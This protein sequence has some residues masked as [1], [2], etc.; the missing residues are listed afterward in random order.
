MI[1]TTPLVR[2]SIAQQQTCRSL[3]RQTCR[4]LTAATAGGKKASLTE[5]SFTQ[6]PPPSFPLGT[7]KTSFTSDLPP[8]RSERP[9]FSVSKAASTLPPNHPARIRELQT[10]AL[11]DEVTGS[12]SDRALGRELVAAWRKDGILQIQFPPGLQVLSDAIK[13]S[14]AFF[15]LPHDK[16][17]KCVDSQ[18]FAGYI[19]SGEEITDGIADYSEIF[20]VTKDLAPSDSRV[21]SKW[22]CHGPCPWPSNSY[23]DAITS[24]MNY[25]G[26]I[27]QKLLHLTALGLNLS[28]PYALVNLTRDGWHHMRVLRFPAT[29]ATNGKGKE[30][31]GIG[32]H[33]DYGLLV[34]AAQDEVGGLFVRPPI[35]GEKYENWKNSAAGAYEDDSKWVYVAPVENVFTVFPGD[36]LQFMTNSYLP[37]TPHKV[38][39][40]TR[41]RFAFAYFHE[42]NFNAVCKRLPDFSERSELSEQ[43]GKS[44]EDQEVHYGTHFTNMF[45]RNYLERITAKRM[46]EEKRMDLLEGMKEEHGFSFDG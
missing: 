27:G 1:M 42:P 2:C 19:A 9:A 25:K 16:K 21:K 31:R 29:N 36:M 23:K 33:T 28:N 39:L 20:T 10:F 14:K 5:H 8:W 35:E 11:P 18:S 40:N 45:M 6:T 24:L 44:E 13:K 26:A 46:R 12:D 17:A 37:S 43:N 38:G 3:G 41:E 32:S 34:I 7:L 4:A 15:A 22:P 30:G